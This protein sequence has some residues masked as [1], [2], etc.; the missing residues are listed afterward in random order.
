MRLLT[1]ARHNAPRVCTPIMILSRTNAHH[2]WLKKCY[3]LGPLSCIYNADGLLN[4]RI[5]EW[6]P[7]ARW[8]SSP[9]NWPQLNTVKHN[10]NA[11]LHSTVCGIH[12]HTNSTGMEF[13]NLMEWIISSLLMRWVV[14]LTRAIRELRLR[15]HSFRTSLGSLTSRKFTTPA[16]LSMRA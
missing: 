6:T 1:R 7:P 13:Y 4:W 10:K 11:K 8:S 5:V 15:D 9:T 14:L 16:G 12:L 3:I 2:A